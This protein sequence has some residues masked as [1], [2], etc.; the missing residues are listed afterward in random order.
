MKERTDAATRRHGDT[1]KEMRTA[2]V[3]VSPRHPF[4]ASS[5][6]SAFIL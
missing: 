5:F 6:F 1:E 4:S 3:P 2:H